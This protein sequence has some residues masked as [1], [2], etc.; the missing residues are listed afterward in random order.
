MSIKLLKQVNF[1]ESQAGLGTVG[2][3]LLD[4]TGVVDV[5]IIDANSY[6]DACARADVIFSSNVVEVER[7]A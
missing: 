2:F 7:V 3:T 6:E 4:A 5:E 1:G